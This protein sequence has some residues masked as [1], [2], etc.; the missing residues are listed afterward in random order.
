MVARNAPAK[1]PL[2]AARLSDRAQSGALAFK[3]RTSAP[4]P[5][6]PRQG[7]PPAGGRPVASVPAI[8]RHAEVAPARRT[9]SP[10]SPPLGP[11]RGLV[12]RGAAGEAMLLALISLTAILMLCVLFSEELGV[13]YRDLIA[14]KTQRPPR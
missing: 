7:P 11:L 5:G 14:R 12:L 13:R 10:D 8:A 1:L 3:A 4:A 2:H 6:L 9:A